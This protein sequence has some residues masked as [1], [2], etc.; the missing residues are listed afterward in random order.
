M[1]TTR[2]ARISDESTLREPSQF[3]PH[4]LPYRVVDT[5]TGRVLCYATTLSACYPTS[6]REWTRREEW[7]DADAQWHSVG[8]LRRAPDGW[9]L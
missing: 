9:W 7:R 3:D 5:R 4:S 6:E 2:V 1:I 8:E